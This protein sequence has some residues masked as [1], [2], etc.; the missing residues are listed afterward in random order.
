MESSE[1]VKHI[2]WQRMTTRNGERPTWASKWKSVF[3]DLF[4]LLQSVNHEIAYAVT[5]RHSKLIVSRSSITLMDRR[6]HLA[7]IAVSV[8]KLSVS[9]PEFRRNC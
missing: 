9:K 6:P 4:L 3:T 8:V 7:P 1:C 2:H 5:L